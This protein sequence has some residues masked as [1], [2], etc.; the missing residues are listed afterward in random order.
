MACKSQSESAIGNL[1]KEEPRP[2]Q[3]CRYFL[4]DVY[5]ESTPIIHKIFYKIGGGKPC[6]PAPGQRKPRRAKGRV[7]QSAGQHRTHLVP[8]E[9]GPERLLRVVLN[10]GRDQ[11]CAPVLTSVGRGTVPWVE[12]VFWQQDLRVGG[13]ALEGLRCVSLLLTLPVAGGAHAPVPHGKCSHTPHTACRC[14]NMG[15]EQDGNGCTRYILMDA[16]VK[17]FNIY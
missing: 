6:S 9:S 14:E 2:R 1:H 7:Q 17:L 3:L 5:K 15:Q 12:W 8:W 16:N 11:P 4:P 13:N 10:R